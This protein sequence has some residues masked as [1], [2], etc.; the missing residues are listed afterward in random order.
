MEAVRATIEFAKDTGR[1]QAS[2]Q[3]IARAEEEANERRMLRIPSS[4][5]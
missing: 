3:D 4:T 2:R 1:L 5:G